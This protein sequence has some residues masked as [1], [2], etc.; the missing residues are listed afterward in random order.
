MAALANSAGSWLALKE[1]LF[2]FEKASG[3]KVNVSK[4]E[5]VLGGS[6]RRQPPVTPPEW[7]VCR[8]GDYIIS[9]GVPIG[10]D[11]DEDEF[12]TAK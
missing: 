1:E 7:K 12:W 2:L 4:T 11:F 10:N 9:L 6:Y 8:E 5:A 3:Q